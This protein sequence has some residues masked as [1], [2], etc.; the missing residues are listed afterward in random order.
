MILDHFKA[1]DICNKA[2][3]KDPRSLA[4]VPDHFKTQDMYSK[5]VEKDPCSLMSVPDHFKTK[6]CVVLK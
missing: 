4:E 2:I 5:A 1:Q 6:T 3:D